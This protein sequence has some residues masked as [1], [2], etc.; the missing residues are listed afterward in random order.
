MSRFFLPPKVSSNG[1]FTPAGRDEV[2]KELAVEP[3]GFIFD[4]IWRKCEIE[5][6]FDVIFTFQHLPVLLFEVR[7]QR[8]DS[9]L[10]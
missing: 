4:A 9:W 3:S 6:C 2:D 1:L 5:V 8:L 10:N 7:R